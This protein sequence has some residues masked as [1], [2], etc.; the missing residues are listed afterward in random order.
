MLLSVGYAACHWCHVMEHESFEDDSI[1]RLMNESL[2]QRQGRPRGTA[3]RGRALHGRRR[4]VDGPRRLAD[5][6]L[7]HARGRAFLRR[8]LLPARAAPRAAELSAAAGSGVEGLPREPR[9]R[10]SP[11][12][13]ARRRRP[14]RGRSLGRAADGEPPPRGSSESALRASIR[15]TAASAARPSS[16]PPRC[17]SSCCACTCVAT[18]RRCRWSSRRSTAWPPAGCTTSSAAA[19]TATRWTPR[20]WCRTS[21]RCS[22]TT[23][24]WRRTTCTPGS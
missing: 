10:R 19:S 23:R 6:G 21:R 7:P 14:R 22:T 8:D 18:R 16:R 13:L 4:G 15:S 24:S 5:D 12:A 20:G 3:G 1:A 11:G 17:S 2:R 9:R